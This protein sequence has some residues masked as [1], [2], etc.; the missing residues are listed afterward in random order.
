MTHVGQEQRKG[1]ICLHLYVTFRHHQRKSGSQ[2]G[3]ELMQSHGEVLICCL[4]LVANSVWFLFVCLLGFF[5][6]FLFIEYFLYLHFKCFLLSRSPLQEPP[7]HPPIPLPLWG[8]SPTHPLPSSYPGIP[9]HW[10]IEHPQAQGS[11]LTDVQQH[12]PLPICCRS[13]GSLQV[14]SLIGGPVP[15]SS[16]GA[17][18]GCWHCCS[19][20]EAASP[21][22]PFCPFPNSSI[23]DP[24]LSPMLSCDHPPLYLSGSGRAS[25]E[26]AM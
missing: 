7:S 26:T 4:L 6:C 3:Q 25:Q 8:C 13:H 22:S 20:N 19:P 2:T 5:I 11:L 23:Q 16:R 10:G 9:R 21:F 1:F 17:L 12:H 14:Y 15:W 18:A 24:M